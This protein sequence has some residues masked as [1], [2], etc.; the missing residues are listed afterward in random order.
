MSVVNDTPV[1][2]RERA[3]LLAAALLALLAAFHLS[4]ALGAPWGRAAF[5]GA[6]GGVLSP[7]LRAASAG[8]VVLD[9][10]LAGVLAGVLVRGRA[11]RVVLWVLAGYFM[12][13]TVMNAIS[14]S[15]VERAIWTPVALALSVL[16]VVLAVS[17]G[18]RTA[19]GEV[20]SPVA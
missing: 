15:P 4:L 1:P 3:G 2:R 20:V 17:A 16:A 19:R 10:V 14:P 18:R 9:V 11:R 7:G 8:A 6:D 5:G 13:G 12:V